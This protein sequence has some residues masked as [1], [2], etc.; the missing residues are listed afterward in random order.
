MMVANAMQLGNSNIFLFSILWNAFLT[1]FFAM[2]TQYHT[3]QMRLSEIN[4]VDEGSIL[5]KYFRAGCGRA[6]FLGYCYLWT[7]IL[8][9]NCSFC[10]NTIKY[11][12][13]TINLSC[14]S[15]LEFKFYSNGRF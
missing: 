4:A 13:C 5:L 8:V 3:G 12:G 2:W 14:G 15:I 10:R 1:F 7:G 6:T 11:Y 9:T